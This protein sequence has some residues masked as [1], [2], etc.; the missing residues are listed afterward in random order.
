M[1]QREGW[2]A[3]DKLLRRADG[4]YDLT[5]RQVI[6]L[7]LKQNSGPGKAVRDFINA[8]AD[9]LIGSHASDIDRVDV[10]EAWLK[11]NVKSD[12]ANV[13]ILMQYAAENLH[14]AAPDLMDLFYSMV[15]AGRSR[16]RM[17]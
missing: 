6:L 2:L 7:T 17:S 12:D 15:A 5:L 3:G 8:L 14:Q 16:E 1:A 11:G 4:S 10:F 9:A 13:T